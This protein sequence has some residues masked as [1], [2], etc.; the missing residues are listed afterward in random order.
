M[1][2]DR[3]IL[4]RGK[5]K[6]K[7]EWVYGYLYKEG[8]QVFILVG[9][10]FYPEPSNGQSVLGIM[11]WYEVFPDS[12]GQFTG[13]F[14]YAGKMIFE[15]D[16]LCA[17]TGDRWESGIHSKYLQY[18]QVIYNPQKA[19]FEI[20][21]KMGESH[22]ALDQVVNKYRALLCGNIHDNKERIHGV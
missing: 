22:K 14:D 16:I 7:P 12:V 18:A 17:N 15:D 19:R 10:R 6:G 3:E 13:F 11:D 20:L 2:F 1:E 8:S 5:S 4:F 21:G 9:D